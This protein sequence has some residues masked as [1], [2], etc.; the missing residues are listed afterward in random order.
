[1]R[2]Q[3]LEILRRASKMAQ[4]VRT[5]EDHSLVP[6]TH[7]GRRQLTPPEFEPHTHTR[8]KKKDK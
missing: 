8:Y 5:Y 2:T 3:K 7:S 1:M 6:R 4:Q